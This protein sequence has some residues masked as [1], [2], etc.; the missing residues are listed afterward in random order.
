MCVLH[1]MHGT[2]SDKKLHSESFAL[3][4]EGYVWTKRTTQ[5]ISVGGVRLYVQAMVYGVAKNRN[6]CQNPIRNE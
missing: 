5:D 6:A 4:A 2:C 3:S 1:T